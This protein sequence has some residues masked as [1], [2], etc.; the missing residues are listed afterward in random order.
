VSSAPSLPSQSL[1]KTLNDEQDRMTAIGTPRPEA[2]ALAHVSNIASRECLRCPDL[3]SEACRKAKDWQ[4]KA[5]GVTIAVNLSAAQFRYDIAGKVEKALT[6]W[7]LEPRFLELEITESI[8][9]ANTEAARQTLETLRDMGV[10]IALDDFGTGYSSLSYLRHLPVD[11]LKID[12]S[13]IAEIDAAFEARALVAAIANLGDA[14]GMSVTAEGV[15]SEDQLSEVASVGCNLVQGFLL[16]KPSMASDFEDVL[17]QQKQLEP[18][19][20]QKMTGHA[21]QYGPS[22]NRKRET[23]RLAPI[24]QF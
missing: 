9:L 2:S 10:S 8:L 18:V 3:L 12:R 1:L 21:I 13:F 19:R 4:D 15:E 22:R 17:I 24:N 11:K 7:G 23:S 14:L 5:Y 16:A 6:E 20:Q